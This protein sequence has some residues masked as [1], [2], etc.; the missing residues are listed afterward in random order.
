MQVSRARAV[1]EGDATVAGRRRRIEAERVAEEAAA[2]DAKSKVS[3]ERGGWRG[4]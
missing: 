3:G 1:A 4:R 2:A